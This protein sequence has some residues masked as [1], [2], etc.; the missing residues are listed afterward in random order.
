MDEIIAEKKARTQRDLFR[1]SHKINMRGS[2]LGSLKKNP[3]S[4]T[5]RES[6]YSVGTIHGIV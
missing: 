6:L 1:N 4:A 5:V 3:G 2:H